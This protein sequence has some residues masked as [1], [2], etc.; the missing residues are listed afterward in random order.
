MSGTKSFGV[1]E[2]N[3][4]SIMAFYSHSYADKYFTGDSRSDFL[5]LANSHFDYS[6]I[7]IAYGITSKFTVEI[8]AGYYLNKTQNYDPTLPLPYFQLQGHG[9]ADPS[10]LLKYN[11]F[12]S[13]DS[14]WSC[15][16]IGGAKFP[17]GTYQEYSNNVLLTQDVQSGTGAYAGI[18]GL[19][20]MAKPFRNH[21]NFRI[22]F[23]RKETSE[24]TNPLGYKYGFATTN[25]ISSS[26]KL[27]KQCSF[28]LMVQNENRMRDYLN[29][30]IIDASGFIKV[31]AIPAIVTGLGKEWEFGAY[32]NYPFYQ[33][34]NGTQFGNSYSISATL[35][36]VFG[37]RKEKS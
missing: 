27:F 16:F 9:L 6:S 37:L 14:V 35:S 19:T 12:T 21:K 24:G 2:K 7:D 17:I 5:G 31:A 29:G 22:I 3:H 34:Y 10:F 1:N 32:F 36:K 13:Q 4:L 25:S 15:T 33:K 20:I 28:L 18:A 8:Q 30:S 26:F 23:N 11:L